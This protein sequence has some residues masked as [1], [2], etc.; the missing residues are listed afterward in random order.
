MVPWWTLLI[1]GFIGSLVGMTVM[2]L[3]CANDPYKSKE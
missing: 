2:A 3:V 1:A